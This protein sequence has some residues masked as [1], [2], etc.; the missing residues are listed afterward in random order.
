MADVD[1]GVCSPCVCTLCL[2]TV[3][4]LSQPKATCVSPWPAETAVNIAYACNIFEDEMDEIFIVEG[5]NDETVGGELR[6][7]GRSATACHWNQDFPPISSPSMAPTL[8][9]GTE[10][11]WGRAKQK[12]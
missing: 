8:P 4:T 1:T 10:K 5:N 11:K 9:E 6:Y 2:R 12:S 7:E 3:K